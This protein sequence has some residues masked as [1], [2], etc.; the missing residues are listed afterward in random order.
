MGIDIIYIKRAEYVDD[1]KSKLAQSMFYACVNYLGLEFVSPR[2]IFFEEGTKDDHYDIHRKPPEGTV[3]RGYFTKNTN[4]ININVK[5]SPDKILEIICHEL[6]HLYQDIYTP[7]MTRRDMERQANA[8]QG[9][10]WDILYPQEE[11]KI[12]PRRYYPR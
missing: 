9:M 3:L 2:M 8:F 10:A 11:E 5:S 4:L 6:C 1:L 12:L 7:K